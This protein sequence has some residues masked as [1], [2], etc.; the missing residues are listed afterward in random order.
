MQLSS[1]KRREK[2]RESARSVGTDWSNGE[3]GEGGLRV[4]FAL[5]PLPPPL[6]TVPVVLCHELFDVAPNQF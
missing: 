6:Q 3:V 4:L 1:M 2:R 5:P